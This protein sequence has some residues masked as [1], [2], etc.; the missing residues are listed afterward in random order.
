MSNEENINEQQPE[1]IEKESDEQEIRTQSNDLVDFRS[2]TLIKANRLIQNYKYTLSKTELRVLNTIISNIHSPLYDKKLNVMSFDIKDFLNLLGMTD[3]YGGADRKRLKEILL[4]LSNKS[5][6]YIEFEKNG[7]KYETIVRWIEKPIFVDENTVELKLD[8]D[9]QPFL[10]QVGSGYMRSQLSYY[11]DMQ[12]KYGIRLYELLKSWEK[13]K[14]KTFALDEL[15]EMIDADTASYKNNYANFRGK[16]LD[17]A[18]K[19]INEITDLLVTY[20]EIKK[21][22]KV[23]HI[24]FYINKKYDDAISIIDD[25]EPKEDGTDINA[26]TNNPD[27]IDVTFT[28]ENSDLKEN[29]ESTTQKDTPEDKPKDMS[30]DSLEAY[31]EERRKNAQR[32]RTPERDKETHIYKAL[33]AKVDYFRPALPEG[34]TEEQIVRLIPFARRNCEKPER[35][36]FDFND[37]WESIEEFEA[38]YDNRL[39]SNAYVY[40]NEKTTKLFH[41]PNKVNEEAYFSWLYKA[42]KENWT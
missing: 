15:R 14:K 7:K 39:D 27:T 34:M 26:Q 32:G 28:V 13:A 37:T 4:N 29:S 33:A 5:S 2:Q 25:E 24:E 1:K 41:Q 40:M 9:L 19:E 23:S 30:E 35:M 38:D 21:V 31:I 18:I 36:Y 10:L 20:K 11:F 42:M 3:S 22:R 17:V 6:D 8:D 16:V 12:S